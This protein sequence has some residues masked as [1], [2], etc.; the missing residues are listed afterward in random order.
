MEKF[1]S[2]NKV[3]VIGYVVNYTVYSFKSGKRKAEIGIKDELT[4]NI[5]YV[6]MFES[7]KLSYDNKSA[8]L[9]TLKR[10]FMDAEGKPR[11]VLVKAT[12]RVAENAY[13]SSKSGQEV[14]SCKPTIW[15][16]DSFDDPAEQSITFNLTGIVESI[17]YVKD[18]TE[19]VVRLGILTTGRDKEFNGVEYLTCFADG[20]L[21]EKFE[22]LDIDKGF[23]IGIA[24]DILNRFPKRDKYGEIPEGAVAEKGF[25]V[26]VLKKKVVEAD[27]LDQ[28]LYKNLKKADKVYTKTTSDKSSK[29]DNMADKATDTAES[30]DV[31]DTKEDIHD[32]ETVKAPDGLDF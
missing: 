14:V 18:D 2:F 13:I 1:Q 7:D 30:S 16:I 20:E 26:M 25:K 22:E 32:N 19:V 6:Q 8:N 5:C 24:G 31:H 10:I 12:G 9:D 17:K 15:K 29:S 23:Q 11:H 27:D 4:N 21:V 3:S 28:D